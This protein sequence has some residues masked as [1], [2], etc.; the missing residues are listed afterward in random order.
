MCVC[1]YERVQGLGGRTFS[2]YVREPWG[3]MVLQ[4]IKTYICQGEFNEY[5]DIR[6]AG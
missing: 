1:A 3:I 2:K 5:V 4:I 6:P